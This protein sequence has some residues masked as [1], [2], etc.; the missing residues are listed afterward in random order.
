MALIFENFIKTNEVDYDKKFNCDGGETYFGKRLRCSKRQ[1]HGVISLA[2]GLASSCNDVMMQLA[3]KMGS[4]IFA[5]YQSEFMFGKKTNIDLPGEEPGLVFSEDRLGVTE[6]A[7]SSFGQGVSVNMLQIAAAYASLVNG[8]YYYEPHIMKQIKNSSGA[9]IDRNDGVLVKQTVSEETSKFIREASL[10]AVT[11]GTAGGA[12]VDNY[13]VGGKTGTAQKQ[14]YSSGK[15]ILSF[16]GGV[17][18]EHPEVIIYVTLN[19]I[20]DETVAKDSKIATIFASDILKNIL[21][22]LGIYPDG[23]ID[24]SVFGVNVNDES[25][26]DKKNEESVE[27]E[28][29]DQNVS[30]ETIDS[31]EDKQEIEDNN[32]DKTQENS[33]ENQKKETGSDD[34]SSENGENIEELE[35]DDPNAFSEAVEIGEQLESETKQ[36]IPANKKDTQDFL[37]NEN[38]EDEVDIE[39]ETGE[40]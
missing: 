26:D 16:I 13:T 10:L 4:K 14:P 18:M 33:N 32:S 5:K 3:Q 38:L 8:G 11:N 15:Y 37:K 28:S 35:E 1:G 27:S 12:H 6:L 30:E 17:P 19:E 40:E 22:Y 34:L 36:N 9:V 20:E 39:N 24:Y 23:E 25:A 21:P 7:S 29:S 2:Q 31:K